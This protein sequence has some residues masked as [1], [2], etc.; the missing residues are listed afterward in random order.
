MSYQKAFLYVE[1]RKI[2]DVAEACFLKQVECGEPVELIE[3]YDDGVFYART[4]VE[5]VQVTSPIQLYL[6]CPT[7]EGRGSRRDA[8]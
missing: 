5:G 8:S 7:R 3:S 6:D 2:S 1:S 4:R